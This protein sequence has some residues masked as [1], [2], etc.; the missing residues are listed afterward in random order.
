MPWHDGP[1][2]S[3]GTGEASGGVPAAPRGERAVV[4]ASLAALV[5]VAWLYLLR[6]AHHMASGMPMLEGLAPQHARWTAADLGAAVAMWAVMMVGMMVPAAAPVVLLFHAVNRKR[7]AQGGRAV[8]TAVFVLGY[9][10]VWGAF[11]V[12]AAALQGALQ[13][14]ALLSPAL[15]ATSPVLGGA[16]LVAAGAWQLTPLKRACLAHCRSPLGF[17][18]THWRDGVTGALRMG[19]AHGAYCLG[20][21]AVLMGLLFVAGVM[22]LAWVAGITA[23]VL[24]EKVAPGGVAIGRVASVALIAAGAVL[25]ARGLLA[26]AA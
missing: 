5:L 8:P 10:L 13:G 11:S 14:A 25:L 12:G 19:V 4:W 24:L 23:F 9:L 3:A 21:C 1:D 16:L 20:C 7:R 22:N 26:L 17:F 6:M 18:L 2:V 15:A